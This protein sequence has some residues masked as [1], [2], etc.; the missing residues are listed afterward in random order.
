M[1]IDL[2]MLIARKYGRMEEDLLSYEIKQA[3]RCWLVIHELI[4]PMYEL[5]PPMLNLVRSAT[6]GKSTKDKSNKVGDG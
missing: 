4:H 3:I 2:M 1:E 5:I 6:K